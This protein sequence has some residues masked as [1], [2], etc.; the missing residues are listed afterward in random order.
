VSVD[1]NGVVDDSDSGRKIG[2]RLG[3][4]VTEYDRL[5]YRRLPNIPEAEFCAST[6]AGQDVVMAATESQAAGALLLTGRFGEPIWTRHRFRFR[7]A[8]RDRFARRPYG[9]SVVEF[10]LRVGA[11]M[12]PVPIVGA[13]HGL[14]VLRISNSAEMAPWWVGG[15]Y[16]R[17][18]ARRILEEAGIPREWFGHQKRLT[19]TEMPFVGI[20]STHPSMADF[21]RFCES[22]AP[23]ASPRRGMHRLYTMN[24]RLNAWIEKLCKRVGIETKLT[25]VV[26]ER[27]FR[28]A[29]EAARLFAY[30]FQWGTER[31]AHRYQVPSFPG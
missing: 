15:N 21:L 26:S 27:H 6:P 23:A 24:R 17:P 20:E 1:S 7:P 4:R 10:R 22:C 11:L 2:E 8:Y 16:D 29:P 3:L 13:W 5:T 12:L 19:A 25:T 28:R 30:S 9:C 18:I 31:I 14:T